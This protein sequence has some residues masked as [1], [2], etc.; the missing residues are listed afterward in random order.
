MPNI[1]LI[2]ENDWGAQTPPF[3]KYTAMRIGISDLP[4]NGD[5]ENSGESHDVYD[6]KINM[7]NLFLKSELKS[8]GDEI[9]M[10]RARWKYGLVLIG[11]AL[12]HDE[13]QAK[14]VKTESEQDGGQDEENGDS[15]EKRV[16]RLTRAIAPVLLPMINSLGAL[17]LEEAMAAVSSGEA[18]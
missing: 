5:A 18:T 4:A 7:D 16:E 12:L 6:F 2:H 8:G 9:E 3:D 13:S 17:E 10:I 1:I 15:V 14:K 11:L